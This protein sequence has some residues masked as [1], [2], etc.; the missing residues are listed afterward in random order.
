MESC[1]S[2]ATGGER[3]ALVRTPHDRLPVIPVPED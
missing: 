2:M 3:P 1:T